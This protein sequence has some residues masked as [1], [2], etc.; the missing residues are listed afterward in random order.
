MSAANPTVSVLMPAWNRARYV[1]EAIRSVLAQTERALELIV[2]DDGS[3]DGTVELVEACMH[4][5][6]LTLLRREHR[7]IGAALNAGLAE[8]RGAWIGRLDSDDRWAPDY[9][10]S[11]LALAARHPGAPAVYARAQAADADLTPKPSFRGAPPTRP[12]DFLGSL[13]LG[14]FTCNITV[15]ARREAVV[16]AGGWRAELPHGE[17][18]DLWLTVARGGAFAFNP[19]VLALYR[20]HDTNVTRRHWDELPDV[21]AAILERHLADPALPEAA[22]RVGPAALRRHHVNAAMTRLVVGRPR[23]ALAELRRA[24]RRGDGTLRVL[25]YALAQLLAWYV[26]PRFGWLRRLHARVL[27]RRDRRRLRRAHA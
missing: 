13:L 4:D 10:A 16:A 9:L 5:D 8:A 6:R 11:Q 20:E 14:D 25:G 24:R 27:E 2:I 23:A 3:T 22:R 21:R 17:D 15:L 1:E 19:D 18:W 26:V 12:D 7:G